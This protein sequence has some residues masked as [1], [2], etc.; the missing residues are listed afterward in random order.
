MWTLEDNHVVELEQGIDRAL[1][2][3]DG[4][5]ETIRVVNGKPVLWS[6]HMERLQKGLVALNIPASME[7][8]ESAVFSQLETLLESTGLSNAVLKLIVSRGNSQRGY[9]Y[10]EDITP[11]LYVYLSKPLET[12]TEALEKGVS[13]KMCDTQCSIQPKLAGLKHLNRIEN[14]LARAEVVGYQAEEQD[15]F[16]GLMI[17]Y[18]GHVVEGTMSNVF[19]KLKGQWVTPELDISGVAGVARQWAIEWF[20]QNNKT[21]VIRHVSQ[22]ELNDCQSGFI[23]NSQ[24]GFVP[25]AKLNNQNLELPDVMLDLQ[26]AWM[27][28]E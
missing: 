15:V 20:Q 13:V 10:S 8:L 25:I 28:Q 21:L 6:A 18:L 9:S 4:L 27:N 7:A 2:F 19:L 11:F 24:M 22:E 12:Y 16:E 1:Q 14:V 26:S 5:F 17:N 3:G 23:C